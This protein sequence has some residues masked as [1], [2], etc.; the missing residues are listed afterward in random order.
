MSKFPNFDDKL[1]SVR[2]D[3]V[4]AKFPFLEVSTSMFFDSST[5]FDCQL[6]FEFVFTLTMSDPTELVNDPMS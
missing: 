2:L 5:S 6:S 4:I 1:A 3:S